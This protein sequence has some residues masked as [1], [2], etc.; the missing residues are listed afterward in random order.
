MQDKS[1][2]KNSQQQHVWTTMTT[3]AQGNY[4]CD[5]C[6][7]QSTSK[8]ILHCESKHNKSVGKFMSLK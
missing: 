4:Q 8:P 5:V 7:K 1:G 2:K 6:M 3:G